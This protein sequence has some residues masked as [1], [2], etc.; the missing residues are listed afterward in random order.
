MVHDQQERRQR[1]GAAE[2]AN[3]LD[4]G[5]A[6]KLPDYYKVNWHYM[7]GGWLSDRHA[8][9]FDFFSEVSGSKDWG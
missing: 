4:P 5:L 6:D 1:G 9:V 3:E 8:R 7:E 2:V